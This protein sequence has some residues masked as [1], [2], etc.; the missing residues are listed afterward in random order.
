M[1]N[2]HKEAYLARRAN[3]PAMSDANIETAG[4]PAETT[5]GSAEETAEIESDPD[6][7]A[8]ISEG[9]DDLT[10]GELSDLEDGGESPSP[11]TSSKPSEVRKKTRSR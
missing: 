6:T 1:T 2:P 10:N 9:E 7:L 11:D 4:I 5:E 8:A 3:G